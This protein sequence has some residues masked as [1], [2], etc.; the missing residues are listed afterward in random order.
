MTLRP[1]IVLEKGSDAAKASRLVATH[2]R[3]ALTTIRPDE[4]TT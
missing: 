4:G 2:T 1:R 3:S